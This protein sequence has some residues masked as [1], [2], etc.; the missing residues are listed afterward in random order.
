MILQYIN[1][2]L[3]E[4]PAVNPLEYPVVRA[5]YEGEYMNST[6]QPYRLPRALRVRPKATVTPVVIASTKFRTKSFD[7]E[8]ECTLIR[9]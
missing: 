7:H 6:A 5:I 1:R 3:L 9:R 2:N 8:E 4:D